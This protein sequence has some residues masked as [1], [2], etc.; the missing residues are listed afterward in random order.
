ML[1]S[2]TINGNKTLNLH[3]RTT[4]DGAFSSITAMALA[5]GNSLIEVDPYSVYHNGKMVKWEELPLSTDD[6]YVTR[7][8]HINRP[9]RRVG[10]PKPIRRYFDIVLNNNSTIHMS[11]TMLENSLDMLSI[12]IEGSAVDFKGSRGLLGDY[13]TGDAI[14]RDGRD[15]GE[16]NWNAYGLEWQVQ[17][18]EPKLFLDADRAPQLPHA[19]CKLPPIAITS[20]K[21]HAIKKEYPRLYFQAQ[22]A[23]AKVG[24]SLDDCM[25]DVMLAKDVKVAESFAM[26]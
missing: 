20:E 5:V 15:M 3:V 25:E 12:S 10:E 13:Y 7:A 24:P 16:H 21:V 11:R 23:C 9:K 4:I 17:E 8:F 19:P 2:G 22:L 6:F 1:H 26:F 14:G 18:D